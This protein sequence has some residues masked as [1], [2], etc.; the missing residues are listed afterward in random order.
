MAKAAHLDDVLA[1]AGFDSALARKRL[2]VQP[3]P[4]GPVG[5]YL[6]YRW[7]RDSRIRPNQS[8]A[9]PCGSVT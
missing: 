6:W 4:W 7:V 2:Q 9:P 3:W 1:A 5:S 8:P